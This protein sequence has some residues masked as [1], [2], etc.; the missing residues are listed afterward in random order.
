MFPLLPAA[1]SDGDRR[2]R[3]G[4]SRGPPRHGFVRGGARA[5]QGTA[6][7]NRGPRPQIPWRSA[8]SHSSSHAC[9]T[10]RG[11]RTRSRSSGRGGRRTSTV[12]SSR[13]CSC[14]VAP[15]AAYKAPSRPSR[16]FFIRTRRGTHTLLLCSFVRSCVRA[17]H[18]GTKTAVQIRSHAQKFFT[19]VVLA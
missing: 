15:G 11:S 7:A 17:V 8:C 10:R 9:L 5:A 4:S 16:S 1:N 3:R 2:D 19:K 12:G 13:P 6:A 18:I 14:T